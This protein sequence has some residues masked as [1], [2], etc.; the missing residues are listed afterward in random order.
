MARTTQ[1][2]IRHPHE[3]SGHAPPYW[4]TA[5]Q[6]PDGA[7][8]RKTYYITRRHTDR[9]SKLLPALGAGAP[10]DPAGTALIALTRRI[11]TVP[12]LD[13]VVIQVRP[14]ADG[15]PVACK[16]Y[17]H[18]HPE[19]REDARIAAWSLALLCAEADPAVQAEALRDRI[20]ALQAFCPA[21]H[22]SVA[23]R[24]GLEIEAYY[25]LPME[26][27]SCRPEDV[28]A[29]VARAGGTRI[30][31]EVAASVAG[32]FNAH[33][34]PAPY[35]G[36]DLHGGT[37]ISVY[38]DWPEGRPRAELGPL[39]HDLS[40]CGPGPV[41]PVRTPP[42]AGEGLEATL[43][44]VKVSATGEVSVSLEEADLS[45]VRDIY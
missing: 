6:E 19:I 18:L 44:P 7:R 17:F 21:F 4:V 14:A 30:Q 20:L 24:P 9:A 15:A 13:G 22:L 29:F 35:T 5:L 8:S 12:C 10:G 33:G 11:E 2:G 40:A 42:S 39:F 16:V 25:D 32:V 38:T 34:L 27:R 43:V 3:I 26:G 28:A 23:M 1:S 37:D 36:C 41:L 45:R 31:A